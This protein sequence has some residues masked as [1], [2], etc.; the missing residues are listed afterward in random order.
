MHGRLHLLVSFVLLGGSSLLAQT[1]TIDFNGSPANLTSYSEYGYNVHALSGSWFGGGSY[2]N[3]A[4]SAYVADPGGTLSFTQAG[5]GD[6]TFGAADLS[7]AQSGTTMTY[8]FVGYLGG[9][10]VF[11]Q[12]GTNTSSTFVTIDSLYGSDVIDTLDITLDSTTSQLFNVDNVVL[13]A[14]AA[15]PEPSSLLLLGTGV[16]GFAGMLKR[17]FA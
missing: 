15:T 10:E 1:V 5:G 11:S 2:G 14:A 8:D 13:T 4:P 9:V 16:L 3:P 7:T 6:F 12:S 17:R